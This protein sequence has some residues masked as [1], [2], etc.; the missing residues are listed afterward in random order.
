MRTSNRLV[1]CAAA[2]ACLAPLAS[3]EIVQVRFD[4]EAIGFTNQAATAL[5]DAFPL[6]TPLSVRFAF[7]SA[8]QPET[9]FGV[10]GVT[11]PAAADLEFDVAGNLFSL[12][13][14]DARATRNAPTSSFIRSILGANEGTPSGQFQGFV[15][16]GVTGNT[17]FGAIAI[18]H[19]P[20]PGT[21][22]TSDFV[23]IV[24]QIIDNDGE[25]IDGSFVLLF[26]NAS[27]DSIAGGVEFRIDEFV[28]SNVPEPASAALLGIA[29]LALRR[30]RP[31]G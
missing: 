30:R 17:S 21:P 14:A 16:G 20:P 8:V 3:A 11:Y 12:A 18:E 10:S 2:S 4:G 22:G 28:S 13:D 15:F 19:N 26:T 1:L 24:Q 25:P 7:D 31:A 23:E 27:D 6:G 5:S 29:G 9:A